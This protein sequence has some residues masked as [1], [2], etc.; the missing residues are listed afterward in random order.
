L[1]E[2]TPQDIATAWKPAGATPLGVRY[3]QSASSFAVVA[4][5]DAVRLRLVHPGTRHLRVCEMKRDPKDELVWT[6]ELDGDWRLWSYAYELDRDGRTIGDLIDPWALLVR[7]NRAYVLPSIPAT[8]PRPPL[9]PKDAILYELHIRDFT[10]DPN[11]GVRPEWAGR[12]LGLTQTGTRYAGTTVTTGL[13]HLVELGVNVVQLMPVHAFSMPYNPVYEWGYMPHDFN[14]PHPTYASGVG[15]EAP[16]VE[17]A[18]LVSAFHERGLRVTLDVVYNHDAEY[19]PT[20]LRSLMGLAPKTYF[21][22]KPDG[23]AFN[24]SGCGN[25]FRSESPHGRRFLIESVLHWVRRYGIDG[26]RFD[27]MGLIDAETMGPLAEAVHQEDP[28]L[29]VYGEPWAGGECGIPV[30][31]KGNQRGKGWGVF[32]DDMRDGLRG[33]VF[34]MKDPGFLNAGTD[35]D[36]V[37]AG[38]RAGIDTFADEPTETVNYIECHDNHTL[39][40]RLRITDTLNGHA[41]DRLPE[42]RHDKMSRLGVLTLMVSQGLPFIHS[43]QEFGRTKNGEDNT[44]NLGDQVN[45]IRWRDKAE[46]SERYDFYRAAIRM[47]AKHPM[48]RLGTRKAVH[49]AV[50]FLD[51]PSLGLNV[52]PGVIAFEIADV[53]GRDTWERAVVALNGSPTR[54]EVPLPKGPWAIATTNGTFETGGEAPLVQSRHTLSGHCGAVLFRPRV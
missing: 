12:Y 51:D 38:I 6:A 32:N 10:R 4:E 15:L 31:S 3:S 40:D 49:E 42:G 53:T 9:D 21:R 39:E 33:R 43:G 54:V 29:L 37:K 11:C 8:T 17:F 47:R 7:D 35:A 36:P 16:V 19:W 50:R 30:N 24:G 25:E 20:K 26:Y 2:T 52:P 14:A 27:L 44:Y 34:D 5:A 18:K 23:T 1:S 22:W 46:R 13:D 48:F 28:T 45:N 41:K